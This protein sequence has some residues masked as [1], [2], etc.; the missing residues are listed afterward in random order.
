MSVPEITPKRG[1]PPPLCFVPWASASGDFQHT[2]GRLLLIFNISPSSWSAA[3]RL[4][5]ARL[6]QHADVRWAVLAEG[7][8]ERW[9][10]GRG[11]PSAPTRSRVQA[12]EDISPPR[13]LGFP[14][15]PLSVALEAATSFLERSSMRVPPPAPAQCW[16]V[17]AFP[18]SGLCCLQKA[19]ICG[20]WSPFCPAHGPSPP[21]APGR[22]RRS[23]A[24]SGL[25]AGHDSTTSRLRA[26][27]LG[28]PPGFV[29]LVLGQGPQRF[30]PY[31]RHQ[32]AAHPFR[33][34]GR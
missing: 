18:C 28:R 12:G 14:P 2:S 9:V 24:E 33:C 20:T 27:R 30:L 6:A 1:T 32:L 19:E 11:L 21:A 22:G 5:H 25:R 7:L 17:A 26:A 29:R 16:E 8:Q 13:S 23:A 15:R 4:P 31:P 34:P 10:H 3:N